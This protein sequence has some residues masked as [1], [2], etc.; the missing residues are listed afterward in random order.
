MSDACHKKIYFSGPMPKKSVIPRLAVTPL[1][2]VCPLCKAKR[3][4]DCTISKGGP[5]VVHVQRIAMAALLDKMG[6]LRAKSAKRAL[7]PF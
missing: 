7:K 1:S 6:V 4:R 2:L 3:G 5:S